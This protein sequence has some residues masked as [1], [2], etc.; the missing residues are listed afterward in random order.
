MKLVWANGSED[1][2]P[3]SD[4]IDRRLRRR[5][6]IITSFFALYWA[7]GVPGLAS[8]AAQLTLLAVSLVMTVV[9]VIHGIRA[10]STPTTTR[11]R[12][13]RPDW[14]LRFYA[15]GLV[16]SFVIVVVIVALLSAELLGV[17]PAAI[18]L[19]VGI[20]FLPLA[21]IF[22]QPEYRWTGICLC[23]VGAAGL[24]TLA[25]T[26]EVIARN[27]VGIGAATVLW[28]T[29]LAVSRSTSRSQ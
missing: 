24:L 8:A 1:S 22:G 23:V 21:R 14:K 18:S 6:A 28:A 15:V 27:T 25:L 11:P 7:I 29:S 9:T 4:E 26:D 19:V 13:L 20:H 17:I 16:Q 12:M 2:A 10:S 3:A 5:G